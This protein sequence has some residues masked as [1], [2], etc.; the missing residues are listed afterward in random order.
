MRRLFTLAS[1]L[2]VALALPLGRVPALTLALSVAVNI[3]YSLPP[4]R[5]SYRT[6]LAPLALAV[7]YVGVPFWL[8]AEITA[9]TAA[10]SHWLLAL[11]CYCLFVGRIVLKDFR[12]RA[13]DDMYGKPTLLLAHGKSVTVMVSAVMVTLGALLL[14]PAQPVAPLWLLFA[15]AVIFALVLKQLV[16]LSQASVDEEQPLIGTGAKLGNGAL[17]ILLGLMLLQ[18]SRAPLS[19]LEL[20]GGIMLLIVLYGYW[21][22]ASRPAAAVN[23]YRG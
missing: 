1:V 4:L 5:L 16:L 22:L 17:I 18:Q 20:F 14:W 15:P 7:G 3:A 12:D 8:G 11:A 10:R 23:T 9:H 6:W 21:Q 19:V 2:A 13:G